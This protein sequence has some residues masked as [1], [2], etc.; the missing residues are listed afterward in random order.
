MKKIAALF[1]ALTMLAGVCL[2]SA[3][4]LLG[5][6]TVL[7][8]HDPNDIEDR[9]EHAL[10]QAL[11]GLVGAKYDDEAV[12]GYQ[13]VSGINYCILCRVTPVVP[14]AVSHWAL[15]YVHEAPDGACSILAVEDLTLALP[16]PEA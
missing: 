10:E 3:E 15:V 5:G 16:Q 2:A 8:D 4:T 14:N 6:W 1:L 13:I 9:A 7:E 12:L 11:Q